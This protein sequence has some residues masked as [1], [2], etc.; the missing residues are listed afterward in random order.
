MPSFEELLKMMDKD[1]DGKISGAEM[2]PTPFKDFFD[3][4]DKNKDNF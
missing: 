4:N 1:A 3:V 2:A